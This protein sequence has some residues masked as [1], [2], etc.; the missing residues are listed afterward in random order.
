MAE[1]NEEESA[2][3]GSAKTLC[4]PNPSCGLGKQSEATDDYDPFEGVKC[5]YCG[6]QAKVTALWGRSYWV[7]NYI[8]QK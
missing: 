4:I 3:T 7:F 1:M 2:L 8:C 6:D 5:F